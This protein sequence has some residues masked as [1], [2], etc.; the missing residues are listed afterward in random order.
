M[1]SPSQDKLDRLSLLISW[2]FNIVGLTLLVTGITMNCILKVHFKKYYSEFK[3]L[4]WVAA[5]GLAVP[6][7]LRGIIDNFK[8][9]SE[10]FNSWIN[11]HQVT[12]DCIFTTFSTL[13]PIIAQMSSLVFGITRRSRDKKMQEAF[14]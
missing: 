7:F 11:S 8:G 1:K 3:C 4:L 6:L 12:F 14:S 9:N 13:I 10:R 2:A 5:I